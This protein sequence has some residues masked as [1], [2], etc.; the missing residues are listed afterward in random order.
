MLRLTLLAGTA[1]ALMP[2]TAAA[3]VAD[4]ADRPSSSAPA[5]A[6]PQRQRQHEESQ[7][8][9]VT[10]NFVRDLDLLSGA[11]V[12]TGEDLV[13]DVRPQ[14]GD[15]LA[16]LPGVSST[17]FSPGSS[18]PVLRGFQGERIRV[19]TDGIGSIDVSNT[20]ADHAVTID[21]LTAERIEVLHGPTVLLFGSQAIG[22]A[23]NVLDRRIPRALPE[24]GVH[25]DVIGAYG[26]AADERSL[27]GGADVALGGGF[28]LHLDGSY[29]KTDD[30]RAGGFV[31]APSLRAEQFAI[32]EEE[33][34][35]GHAEEAEEAFEAANRRS[36]IPNSATEQKTL[37][38][39]LAL[40]RDG[41]SLGFSVSWFDSDYGVPTRPGAGH[42][43]RGEDGD[44]SSEEEAHGDEPVTI[45]L[46]QVRADF[47]AQ[48]NV[49][50][51]F[52]D[53]IRVRLGAA[54]YDHTEF[55]GEEVGTVFRTQGMEG[56]LELVQADRGGW[57]GASGLQFFQRDFE[58]IGA[59]AFVPPN[60]TSQIGLFTLQEFS[61]GAVQFEA[62]GRYERTRVSSNEV[63][64]SR[65]FDAFS[66]A[67]GAAYEPASGVRFGVNLSRSERAPAA[68]ELFSDGPHV[69][70]QAFEIG[71]PALGKRR[72]GAWKPICGQRRARFVCVP[73]LLQTGSTTSSTRGRPARRRTS[74]PSSG[75]SSAMPAITASKRKL[76]RTSSG[77]AA[78]PSEP[79]Q[80]RIMSG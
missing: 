46:K 45:G 62:A 27:G 68:E 73:A 3:Q 48:V 35:E 23:V 4:T 64:V 9:I 24:N 26:S 8:I 77:R 13:R 79:M 52:L 17:S 12:L 53:E 31:L 74:F 19:L 59:E 58:A 61:A 71:D 50:G 37:G 34:E 5:S 11:S 56:R 43:H 69:A 41:G 57:R 33:L 6:A 20:S 75:I 55:E 78:S 22:G 63:G 10:G 25:L 15:T 80:W 54:D 49:R 1:A 66:A 36:R 21:P 72:A 16:R 47:R 2:Y 67:I 39:G 65:R 44:D 76:R 32:A 40:I 42:H 29:R 28:V 30:L 7:E 14:L 18:R 60:E 38:G 70:T 51:D